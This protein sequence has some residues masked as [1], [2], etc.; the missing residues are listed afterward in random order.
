MPRRRYGIRPRR[1]WNDDDRFRIRREIVARGEM[2]P[3]I[4]GKGIPYALHDA[5]SCSRDLQ[6]FPPL[7][8]ITNGP[9]EPSGGGENENMRD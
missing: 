7:A 5:S 2:C 4:S 1:G 6:Y 8:T 9:Q 3:G